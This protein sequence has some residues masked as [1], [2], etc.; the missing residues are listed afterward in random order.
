MLINK[1]ASKHSEPLKAHKYRC[2][3]NIVLQ[4]LYASA[5]IATDVQNISGGQHMQQP[6]TQ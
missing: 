1:A 3:Q 2:F 6:A 4:Q 5:C